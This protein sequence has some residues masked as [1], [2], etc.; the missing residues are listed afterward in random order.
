MSSVSPVGVARGPVLTAVTAR[1][2]P[3]LWAEPAWL[4]SGWRCSGMKMATKTANKTV[5]APNRKGGP[6]MSEFYHRAGNRHELHHLTLP[7]DCVR[8]RARARIPTS[9]FCGLPAAGCTSFSST[10]NRKKMKPYR[11]GPR[12]LHKPLIPVIMPWATPAHMHTH[13]HTT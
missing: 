6:G 13:T 7:G 8:A 2:Y 5:Q 9:T 4:S 10:L 1:A 12:P 3:D 11:A